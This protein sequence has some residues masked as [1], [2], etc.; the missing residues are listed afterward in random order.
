M[1]GVD[2]LILAWVSG[3]PLRAK[4]AWQINDRNVRFAMYEVFLL[5]GL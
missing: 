4:Y 5:A 3:H 2:K 1:N